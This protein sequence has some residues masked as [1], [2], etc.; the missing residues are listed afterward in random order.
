MVVLPHIDLIL[1]IWLYGELHKMIITEHTKDGAKERSLSQSEIID[2]AEL[3]DTK[4]KKE[5]L[6]TTFK[7]MSQDQK[8]EALAEFLGVN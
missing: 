3:G 2:R 5:I 7:A 8:I 4:A 1:H 6:R